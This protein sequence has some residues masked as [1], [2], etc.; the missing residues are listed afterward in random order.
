MK[1]KSSL[2][3][4]K[5]KKYTPSELMADLFSKKLSL[6]RPWQYESE[7]IQ[8]L[9]HYYALKPTRVMEIGTANGGTLFSHC[10]LAADNATI[11]SVD[12]PGGK[13]GGG[14]PD[15][16]IPIYEDFAKSNQ[17][18][19]LI[20]ASSY[21]P[22]TLE[23]VKGILKGDLLDYIFIDGDHTYDGVK[24]DFDMYLPLV[25]PGGSIIFHD[26]AWH[27]NSTCQVDK[28]WQDT[29]SGYKN[30]EF[31]QDKES[32]KFGIGILIK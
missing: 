23:M 30:H 24:K 28:F 15:W 20:R 32:G 26:I 25:K 16:K 29:K 13:F 31:I 22:S 27:K 11:I 6:I 17:N 4:L 14:Y 7:F 10:K 19:H 18:L 12:L 5:D 8:L 3:E 9:E 1:L 21:D 2:K